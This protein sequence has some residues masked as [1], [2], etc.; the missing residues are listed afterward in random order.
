MNNTLKPL[1]FSLLLLVSF[2][3]AGAVAAQEPPT[4][5]LSLA[6][7]LWPDYDRP[8]MLV[9]LTAELP[10]DV[11]LPATLTIPVPAEADIHA[12]ASFN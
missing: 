8:A 6:V 9:L 12:V 4:H 7:E 5:L 1:L 11:T 2:V 3:A 10:P